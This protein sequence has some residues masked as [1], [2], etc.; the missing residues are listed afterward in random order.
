MNPPPG[1]DWVDK[2]CLAADARERQQAQQPDLMQAVTMMMQ[3]QTQTLTALAALVLRM[4][5]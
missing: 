5:D 1:V 2:I 4:D 3:M